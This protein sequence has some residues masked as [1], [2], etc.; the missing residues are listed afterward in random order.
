M[1]FTKLKFSLIRQRASEASE[2]GKLVFSFALFRECPSVCDF[3]IALRVDSFCKF[4][5]ATPPSIFELFEIFLDIW[6]AYGNI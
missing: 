2:A 1:I 4:Q 5:I 6:K 3:R